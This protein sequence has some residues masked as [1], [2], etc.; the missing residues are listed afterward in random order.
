[1]QA[2]K[3]KINEYS[4]MKKVKAELRAEEKEEVEKAEARKEIAKEVRKAKEAEA[5]MDMHVA[6]AADVADDH[7]AKQA[8]HHRD[9]R[10]A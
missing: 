7:I 4:T 8:A 6:K 2:I 3:E 1:M 10:S 5:E 9:H